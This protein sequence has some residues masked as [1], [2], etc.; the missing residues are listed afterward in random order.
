MNTQ[1]QQ[2]AIEALNKQKEKERKQ[3]YAMMFHL[4]RLQ[5]CIL[6]EYFFLTE[7]CMTLKNRST[8]EHLQR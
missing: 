1:Q 7:Y 2:K 5:N 6:M 4:E 3:H 8:K